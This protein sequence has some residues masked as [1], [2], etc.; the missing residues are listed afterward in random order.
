MQSLL[1]FLYEKGMSLSADSDKG[2]LPP[3]TPAAF[4]KAGETFEFIFRTF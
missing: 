1:R 3:L 2:A 4:E